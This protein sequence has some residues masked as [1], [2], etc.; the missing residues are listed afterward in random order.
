MLTSDGSWFILI[1]TLLAVTLR[2]A[3]AEYPQYI[4]SGGTYYLISCDSQQDSNCEDKTLDQVADD[5]TERSPVLDEHASIYINTSH[6]ELTTNALFSGLHSLAISGSIDLNTT[7][8]C[9]LED[10]GGLEFKNITSLLLTDLTIT[11]C[12]FKSHSSTEQEQF[13]SYSSAVTILCCKDVKVS[14]LVVRNNNGIGLKILNHQ[15]GTVHIESSTFLQNQLTNK[16]CL[17]DKGGGGVYVGGFEHPYEPITFQFENCI[18]QENEAHTKYFDYLYTNDL[19][20]SVTGYGSGGGAAILLYN[21]LTNI[22]VTFSGCEFTGNRAFKGGGL[23]AGIKATKDLETS[24][25]TVTV[26]NSLFE[27]NGCNSPGHNV[28]ASGGGMSINFGSKK[29]LT[30]R[31]NKFTIRNVT[32]TGNCARFGGGLYFYS[33]SE[34]TVNSENA[35]QIESC[36]FEGNQAHTGS[37]VDITPNVFQRL[38]LIKGALTTPVFKDCAFINNTVR[39]NFHNTSSNQ[40]TYGIGTLYVSLYNVKFTGHKTVR[41]ENNRGTPIHIVN[42]NIDMSQ[43]SAR[44]H[45]NSGIQG[46]AIALIGQSSIIV[47]PNR[48]YE[49]IN[50]TA[51]GKGG[52]LYVQLDDNHDITASKSC[53]IQYYDADEYTTIIP[54]RDQTAVITFTGKSSPG[55]HRTCHLC[56]V[57]LSLSVHQ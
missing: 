11:N 8:M 20:Q 33:D 7:I 27:G 9:S 17:N 13:F 41:F 51:F 21:G 34:A 28:T 29:N 26:E 23:T 50:N 6:L 14:H 16:S 22:H 31:S 39:V 53:F 55:W 10:Y 48:S 35:V 12:G 40:T 56:N 3:R 19:G 54:A 24:S 47:G 4:K 18:F 15:G 57:S 45:N 32:F 38:S 42:G 43:S 5:F 37:A 2:L 1:C 30:F 52:G 49:F 44:F 25:I 36:T 46:G